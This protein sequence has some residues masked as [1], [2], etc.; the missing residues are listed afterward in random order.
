LIRT[1]AALLLEGLELHRAPPEDPTRGARAV[2]GT[3][4]A[5]LRAANC[6]FRA[7]IWADHSSVCVFR[8]CECLAE[9]AEVG[10]SCLPGARFIFENCL[11]RTGHC[12]ISPYYDDAALHDVSIQIK[13]STFVSKTTSLWFICQRPVPGPSDRS[14]ASQPIRLEV[15]ESIF[16]API[17][18]AFEQ[19]RQLL[20]KAAVPEP[21]ETEA[22]LLRLLEW[23]GER[24]VFATGS[25][26]VWLSAEGKRQTPRGPKNL[27]EWKAFWGAAE[28]DSLEGRLRF[29][30]GDL[31]SRTGADLDQL[32]PDDFRLRPDSAGYRAGPDG[33]DL[34]ADVDLVG[35]GPAYERWKKTP[36]Y[37]QW[38]KETGQ[39]KE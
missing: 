32:T 29:Q 8:N 20:E 4:Q 25:T 31:L 5:P 19:S 24:N 11:H 1:N 2:V 12:A 7:H 9:Q 16:D 26:S 36:E 28:T 23:R 6:R 18:L 10:A 3:H 33:K 38:V 37:Q 15:S 34:G 22:A 13:R 21:A 27:E 14:Q 17:V 39:V 30:G 35:P